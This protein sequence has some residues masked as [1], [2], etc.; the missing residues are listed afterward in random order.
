MTLKRVVF[1]GPIG[2]DEAGD[3]GFLDGEG[4]IVYGRSFPKPLTTFWIFKDNRRMA[5]SFL[6]F[7]LPFTALPLWSHA[8]SDG[9]DLGK[10]SPGLQPFNHPSRHE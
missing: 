4:K 7:Q 6:I 5:A 10:G 3:L 2:P 9:P 8:S 1:P